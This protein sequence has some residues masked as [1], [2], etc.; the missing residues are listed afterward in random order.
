MLTKLFYPVNS[1]LNETA[2]QFSFSLKSVV[3]Q[4]QQQQT[5]TVNL[6]TAKHSKHTPQ[7]SSFLQSLK[8]LTTY[9][10]QLKLKNGIYP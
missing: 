8:I 6:N 1:F 4:T 3:S 5:E 10:I 7:N 2:D 9:Y